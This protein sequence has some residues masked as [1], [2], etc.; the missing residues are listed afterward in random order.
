LKRKRL[1]CAATFYGLQ[2]RSVNIGSAEMTRKLSISLPGFS[3]DRLYHYRSLRYSREYE[4][5]RSPVVFLLSWSAAQA[6]HNLKRTS[7]YGS[8]RQRPVV[9]ASYSCSSAAAASR[10]Q[11]GVPWRTTTTSFY[12]HDYPAYHDSGTVRVHASRF[13][14]FRH[15]LMLPSAHKRI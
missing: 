8:L 6:G 15:S 14:S 12:R 9:T 2:Q 7:N 10:M 1:I 5:N 3:A 4:R 11:R 13:L